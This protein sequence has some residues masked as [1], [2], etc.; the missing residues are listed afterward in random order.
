MAV[1]VLAS[2]VVAHRGAR[3]GTAGGDLDV[4]QVNA[5]SSMVV[6]NVCLSI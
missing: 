6:T 4:A 5:A 2:T 1:E 3:L